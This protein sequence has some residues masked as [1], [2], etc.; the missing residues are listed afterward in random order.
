[1]HFIL[2]SFENQMIQ[3]MIYHFQGMVVT[4]LASS[5]NNKVDCKFQDAIFT[6]SDWK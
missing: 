5:H 1:M 3:V 2:D 6:Y 4:H